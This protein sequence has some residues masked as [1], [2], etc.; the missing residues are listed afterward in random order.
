MT[1][2]ALGLG[3]LPHCEFLR[4]FDKDEKNQDRI[5]WESFCGGKP[6]GP[7][8]PEPCLYPAGVSGWENCESCASLRKEQKKKEQTVL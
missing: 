3:R 8:G 7:I 5:V 1:V 4:A 6:E 2:E